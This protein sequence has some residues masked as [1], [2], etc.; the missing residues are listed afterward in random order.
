MMSTSL[1]NTTEIIGTVIDLTTKPVAR[2]PEAL[3]DITNP[4]D[5]F[6]S[7]VFYG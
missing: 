2:P 5:G 6:V 4:G 1:S 3:I 7:F